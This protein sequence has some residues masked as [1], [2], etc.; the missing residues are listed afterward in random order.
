MKTIF[1][2]NYWQTN[3]NEKEPIEWIVLKEENDKMLVISKYCLDCVPYR[4]EGKNINW[5]ESYMRKWLNKVFI[6]EAFTKEEKTR[7]IL[8]EVKTNRNGWWDYPCLD[9]GPSVKDNVFLLSRSESCLY[10]NSAIWHDFLADQN[11]IARPTNYAYEK[12]C[13]VYPLKKRPIAEKDAFDYYKEDMGNSLNEWECYWEYEDTVLSSFNEDL[14]NTDTSQTL[15]GCAWYLRSP[16]FDIERVGP[17]GSTRRFSLDE[18][19]GT[20]VR[21]AMWIKK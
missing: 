1:W 2:G 10:F 19:A 11:R 14:L 13:W 6:K 7:I 18:L 5:K 15:W 20:A 17:N 16:G 8:S 3:H 9:E 4:Q 21:P 12:G